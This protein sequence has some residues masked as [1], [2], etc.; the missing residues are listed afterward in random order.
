MAAPGFLFLSSP[1]RPLARHAPPPI[2][3]QR[4]RVSLGHHRVPDAEPGYP[5]CP[6]FLHCVTFL[7]SVSELLRKLLSRHSH[8]CRRYRNTRLN[9]PRQSLEIRSAKAPSVDCQ[10]EHPLLERSPNLP[11]MPRTESMCSRFAVVVLISYDHGN[12]RNK[13]AQRV[14][15]AVSALTVS[16]SQDDVIE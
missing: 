5:L 14:S 11:T 8:G 4:C 10:S 9:R 2:P 12:A 1:F 15:G 3:P 7:R 6:V 16:R 13:S